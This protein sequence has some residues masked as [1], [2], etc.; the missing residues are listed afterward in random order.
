MGG[1]HAVG[2]ECHD[3]SR[4]KLGTIVSTR[5]RLRDSAWQGDTR[6]VLLVCVHNMPGHF[7]HL[8]EFLMTAGL[9]E[10]EVGAGSH[11]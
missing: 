9:I 7:F 5:E 3:P 8:L 11:D 10:Q 2:R 4:K 6:D 1:R